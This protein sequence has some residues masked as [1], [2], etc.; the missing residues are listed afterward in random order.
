[1]KWIFSPDAEHSTIQQVKNDYK[2][3]EGVEVFD[4]Y[5]QAKSCLHKYLSAMRDRFANAISRHR[6]KKKTDYL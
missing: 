2:A 1:M 3:P 4:S 5:S 6:D